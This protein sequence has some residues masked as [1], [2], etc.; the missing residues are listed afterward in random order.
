MRAF[1]RWLTPALSSGVVLVVAACAT[2]QDGAGP[3]ALGDGWPGTRTFVATSV[4]ENGA[5]KT[6][7]EGSRITVSFQS[8]GR[9]S[10][11]AG[12]NSMSGT[13]RVE[14]DTLI[15][16]DLAMTEMACSGGLME[17]D[18]WVADL[19][20]SRPTLRLSGDELTLTGKTITMVLVDR[21]I[22]DPDR[23]LANTLWLVDTVF[24]GDTAMSTIHPMPAMLTIDAREGSFR[25]TT[26]CVGGELRG[27]ATVT[28]DQV[29]FAVT[30]DRPCLDEGNP[31]DAAVRATLSGVAIATLEADVLRLLRLD[32]HGVGLTAITPASDEPIEIDCG[33][34]LLWQGESPT[35]ARL[36]CFLEAIEAGRLAQ[37][38]IVA[39]GI[40]GGPVPV[41]YRGDALDRVEVFHDFRHDPLATPGVERQICVGP[42]VGEGGFLAFDQCTPVDE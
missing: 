33:T 41:T 3:G 14:S 27:T 5:P 17:Q 19:L 36:D 8:D 30:N 1:A 34:D 21:E 24:A 29:T 32:G 6:L 10:A 23:P 42:R 40:D 25:A 18:G 39:P 26:G 7:V 22:V 35:P 4:T 28:G 37:V 38:T 9:I 13:A 2:P 11:H 12:C 31:V 16:D 20:T 15:V